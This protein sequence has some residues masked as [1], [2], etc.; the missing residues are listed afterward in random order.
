M[1]DKISSPEAPTVLPGIT[2]TC[3]LGLSNQCTI[4]ICATDVSSDSS[5]SPKHFYSDTA[6]LIESHT[7]TTS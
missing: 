7:S 2:S 5:G 1:V 4:S 6:D 3:V